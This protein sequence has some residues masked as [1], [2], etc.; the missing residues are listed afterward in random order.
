MSAYISTT[1]SVLV[2][3]QPCKLYGVMCTPDAGQVGDMTLY[4]ARGAVTGREILTIRTASGCTNQVRFDGLELKQG[5]YVNE[6]SYVTRM[7]VE[8]EPVGYEKEQAA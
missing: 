5:L 8:W 6:G 2:T 7:T 4:D 1:T 3:A